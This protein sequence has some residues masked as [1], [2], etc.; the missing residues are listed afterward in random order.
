MHTARRH[1]LRH[2]RREFQ[3]TQSWRDNAHYDASGFLWRHW[4]TVIVSTTSPAALSHNERRPF[5]RRTA[6]AA[7]S[8]AHYGFRQKLQ[9][10]AARRPGKAVVATTE[11]YTTK[12]CGRCGRLTSPGASETFVCGHEDCGLRIDRDVNGARNIALLVVTRALCSRPP[13]SGRTA[14]PDRRRRWTTTAMPT[15]DLGVCCA[16]SAHPMWAAE[17]AWGEFRV[18]LGRSLGAQG[19]LG[20][21]THSVLP[22]MET[23]TPPTNSLSH[24]KG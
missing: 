11:E 17:R 23:T 13:S 18:P 5:G 14:R 10:S 24:D 19:P 3:W 12:T 4:D 1:D 6:R 20:S 15:T 9:F 8:W 22:Q 2:A 16:P 21:S 7:Y